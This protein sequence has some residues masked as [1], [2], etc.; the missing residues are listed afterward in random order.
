MLAIMRIMDGYH[1]SGTAYNYFD[2]GLLISI[3][4]LFYANLIWFGLL[5][6]IGIALL[7]TGNLKEI[8]ISVLGF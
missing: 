3:G 8:L 5:V 4:S 7:R 6:I 1:I 2:A